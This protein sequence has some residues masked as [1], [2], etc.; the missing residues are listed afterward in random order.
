MKFKFPP[1]FAEP[2]N[3]AHAATKNYVDTHSGGG[4]GG[5]TKVVAAAVA[6]GTQAG[7]Q[8]AFTVYTVPSIATRG[9]VSQFTVTADAGGTFDLEVRGAATQAGTLWLQAFTVTSL[10]YTNPAPWYVENDAAGSDLFIGI[11]NTGSAPRTFTLTALRVERF[12]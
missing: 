10:S 4:G 7:N 1:T 3:A 9:L 11:R 2:T 5:T 12:A 8:T 6:L